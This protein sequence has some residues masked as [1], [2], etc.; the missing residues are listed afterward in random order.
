QVRV[1]RDGEVREVS[2]RQ[3]VPGDVVLLESGSVVPA[4]GRLLEAYNL[5]VQESALTGE[6]ESVAKDAGV[7]V[8][9]ETPLAER[10]NMLFMGTA[11]VKGRGE[12]IVSET[13]MQTELGRIAEMISAVRREPTPLQRRLEQLG[14]GLA[15]ASVAVVAMVFLLGMIRG[16]PFRLMVMVSIS[17]AVAAVPEGLPAVVT[18]ALTLGARRMLSRNALIRRLAAVESLGSVTVICSDKTGTLTENRMTVTVLDLAGD[19]IN[20]SDDPNEP[21]YRLDSVRRPEVS[22][23]LVAGALCSDALVRPGREPNERQVVGDP[24][25]GALVLA[26]MRFGLEKYE[27]EKVLPRVGEVPFTTARKRMTTMHRIPAAAESD[28][29]GWLRAVGTASGGAQL[30]AFTKGAVDSLLEIATHVWVEGRVVPMSQTWRTRAVE[31]NSRLAG[32]GMRVLGIAFRPLSA[33]Q[34]TWD[35]DGL[36][37]DLT[38]V[39][40]V[41]MADPVRREA[42]A[43][44]QTCRRAGIR[45]LMITGD[46]PL[47]AKAIARVL[48]IEAP[49]VVT[50]GQELARMSEAELATVV[51]SQSIF[52]RVDPEYKLAIVEALQRQGHVVAMTGD[53]V[54]DAPALKKADIGVAMGAVGTDVAKEASDMVLLDDNFATIVAAVEEG[55]VVYDNVRKFV[56]FSIG[57]NIGK[58]LVVVV[59]PFLGMPLPLLPLQLLWLNLLTDGLLGLGLSVEPAERGT[60]ARPPRR[61][62]ESIL[63]GGAGT[64][65]LRVGTGI[66]VAAL[67]LGF[68]FWRS[69]GQSPVWQTVVFTVLAF[70]QAGQAIAVRTDRDSVFRVGL[71]SNQA[72]ALTVVLVVGLQLAAVYIPVLRR[73]F[74]TVPLSAGQLA[75][76]A[77]VGSL[78]FWAVELEKLIARRRGG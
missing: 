73:I 65:M 20:I 18:I 72:Q 7:V 24:T 15:L 41:A 35:A 48:R 49:D 55:R 3:L 1:R 22:L 14:R 76:C 9:E 57:G 74:H 4:D 23:M 45:P 30:I 31:A 25:E 5:E 56:R 12:M 21:E 42:V 53:G 39:G 43:A 26:A 32:A 19:T 29:P 46:H 78:A 69:G 28:T 58:I 17:M 77:V 37:R 71:L 40:L 38:F 16:E 27:L 66:G 6:S 44:V 54:N 10:R 61:L 33:E 59:A 52:A 75:V 60:M 2:A 34:A 50:T 68:L 62:A 13:G 8:L 70:L 11:V 63:A 67:A 47:T 64:H 36:E 51:S